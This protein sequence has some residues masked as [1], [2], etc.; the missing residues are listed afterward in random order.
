VRALAFAVLLIGG[1][2]TAG[3][4]LRQDDPELPRPEL[5]SL[6]S[7]TYEPSGGKLVET[8]RELRTYDAKGHAIRVDSKR[9]DGTP[10]TFY[11]QDGLR[12]RLSLGGSDRD[13]YCIVITCS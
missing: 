1:T 8:T 7:T 4:G 5:R 2:A 11:E 13:T 3:D 12:I 9:P 6:S 10:V